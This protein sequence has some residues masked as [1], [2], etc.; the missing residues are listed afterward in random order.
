MAAK[1][2]SSVPEACVTVSAVRTVVKA[3][4][5]LLTGHN[6]GFF[7][8]TGLTEWKMEQW[9]EK[10]F[11]RTWSSICRH[12]FWDIRYFIINRVRL[13]TPKSY[14]L[15][16]VRGRQDRSLNS[17]GVA[18]NLYK[19]LGTPHYKVGSHLQRIQKYKRLQ[20]CKLLHIASITVRHHLS[21]EISRLTIIGSTNFKMT[22]IQT[23]LYPKGSQDFDM[24]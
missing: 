17:G 22:V 1:D 14:P 9:K 15:P 20:H 5:G 18:L 19:A 23:L 8:G 11:K 12:E 4:T 7:L 3:E 16:G 6:M 13:E 21:A 10:R 24:D 2:S